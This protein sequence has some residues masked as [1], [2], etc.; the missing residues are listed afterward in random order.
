LNF[1]PSLADD[2]Q[3]QVEDDVEKMMETMPIDLFFTGSG[4]MAPRIQ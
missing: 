1:R 2:V 3:K 4:T